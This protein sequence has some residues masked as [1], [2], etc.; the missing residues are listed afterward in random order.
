MNKRRQLAIAVV[1][2]GIAAC[3]GSNA[4]SGSLPANAS[5]KE[6]SRLRAVYERIDGAPPLFLNWYDTHL[7]VDCTFIDVGRADGR[8]VCYPSDP[9]GADHR[10]FAFETHALFTDSAC[11][12]AVVDAG[13]VGSKARFFASAPPFGA[14]C[15][16][17]VR[18]YRLGAPL[19][20]EANGLYSIV[21]DGPCHPA[22]T[23][24]LDSYQALYTLGEEIPLEALVSGTYQH[25]AAAGRIVPLR[26]VGSDGAIQGETVTDAAPN[27]SAA[28]DNERDEM[29][30]TS[31]RPGS[32]WLP[33]ARYTTGVFS[34][35]ACSVV[36]AI[37]A[38]CRVSAKEAFDW[39]TDAC[40]PAEPTRFYEL[41]APV[42]DQTSV[43]YQGTQADVCVP[44]DGGG[45]IA[46]PMVAAFSVGAVIPSTVFAEADEVHTG[47]GQIKVVQA[48]SADAPAAASV[49]L[50]DSAHGVPCTFQRNL[51]A[52]DGVVRC[53][54]ETTDLAGDNYADANCTVPLYLGGSESECLPLPKFTSLTEYRGTGDGTVP[55]SRR[56]IFPIGDRYTG[57]LYFKLVG[58]DG[59]YDLGPSA[60]TPLYYIGSEVPAA[61]FAALDYVRPN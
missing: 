38:A 9:V 43:Y 13:Y 41:G 58:I 34:D 30:S 31:L 3:S 4:G 48:G 25:D 5:F 14:A 15:G 59:C 19:P 57:N 6:G 37:G 1:C 46:N 40:G 50:F 11:T 12:Q 36:A 56:R 61:E 23:T 55:D 53:L 27:G 44:Y 10:L 33:T 24:E 20:L 18:L 2:A 42:A 16:A 17:L 8:L 26:I 45:S 21:N 22:A 28:W 29:V 35:A 32:R 47:T 39:T 54:P 49:G 7:D 51:A 60:G 52:A